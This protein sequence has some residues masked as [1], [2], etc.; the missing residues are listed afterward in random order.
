[1]SSTSSSSSDSMTILITGASRGF[2]RAI[3]KVAC[4]HFSESHRH[5]LRLILVARSDSGLQETKELCS[6]SV[7]SA[8][9]TCH[10]MD[11]GDLDRLD[12]NMDTLMKQLDNDQVQRII[13]INNAGTIG[14]LGPCK[15]SPSLQDMRSNVDLNITSAL[16]IAVRFCRHVQQQQHAASSSTMVNISSLVAIADF[17]TF[18]IYSAGKAARDKY[19]TL[20]AKEEEQGSKLKT[21]N[22]APGPL[23]TDMVEEIRSSD[24]LDANLKPNYQKKL[25]DTEDSAK[26]LIRLLDSN[27]FD[28]GAHIDY[29]DL[30]RAALSTG[31]PPSANRCVPLN[32]P[33]S[34]KYRW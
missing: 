2:G 21:L 6:K 14:H 29:Y 12:E 3:A 13:C 10:A 11:L 33:I 18:G 28:S 7:V 26:K 32:E 20:I 23:E 5:P 16:W 15:E 4:Q 9:I 30:Q 31:K 1:M 8:K 17:P 22:Y 25:L 27:T 19:H 24:K 34:S